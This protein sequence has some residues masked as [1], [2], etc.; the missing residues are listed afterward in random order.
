MWVFSFLFVWKYFFHLIREIKN[1]KSENH[2]TSA[3]DEAHL[4]CKKIK[5]IGETFDLCWL[6]ESLFLNWPQFNN[7]WIFSVMF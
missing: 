2:S 5:F 6:N 3:N 1:E 4:M 7:K